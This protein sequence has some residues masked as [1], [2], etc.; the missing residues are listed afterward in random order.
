MEQNRGLGRKIQFDERSRAYPIRAIVDTRVLRGYTWSCIPRLDQG[1]EG[2]CVGFA[3]SHELAAKPKKVLNVTDDYARNIYH[4]AQ[5]IDEWPGGAYPGASPFYEGTS[6]LAGAKVVRE[7]GAMEQ[8][9]W[10][11]NLTDLLV[12]IGYTGPVVLGINWYEG[13]FN[14]DSK[15]F[16]HPTGSIAGGHAI[17]ANGV[18]IRNKLVKL[19][20]SWGEDW[21]ING[22]CYISWDDIERLLHEQG[23][24]C[25]PLKRKDFKV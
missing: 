6:V 3:W 4:D 19:H 25:V 17:I 13:M 16:I 23:E 8:Y 12:A 9:R 18:S 24:A 11:F 5:K 20:N 21:G 1:Y 10:C 14:P 2:A 15:G 7:R 22:E